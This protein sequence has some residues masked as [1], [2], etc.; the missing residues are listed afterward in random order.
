VPGANIGNK[1]IVFEP[2]H[3]SA[4]EL[5]SNIANPTAT[6]LSGIMMLRYLGEREAADKIE[7]AVEKVLGE[8]KK[9]TKDLG[10]NAGTLE[11]TEE[12]I[13]SL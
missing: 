8:R 2:T 4:P 12:I 3:G 7:K 1:E 6:I 10:G 5:S 9:I 13:N 11:Y